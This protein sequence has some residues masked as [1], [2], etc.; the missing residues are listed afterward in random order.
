MNKSNLREEIFKLV[1]SLEVQKEDESSQIDLYLE[2]S[3]LSDK[4]KEK[5]KEEVCKIIDL[6]EDIENQISKNL[7][8]G[9]SIERISKVNISI[10]RIAIYEMIYGKLPYKV[11]INEAVELAKKYGEEV[12]ASFIN[13]VLASV[14]K[15]NNITE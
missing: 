5:I 15:D 12:S 8:S 11:V 7:K 3:E 6:K 1:Y 13:G 10:L 9:W 2:N 4:E 14:V